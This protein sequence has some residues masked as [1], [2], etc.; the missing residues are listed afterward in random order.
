MQEELERLKRYLTYSDKLQG[1][2]PQR[3]EQL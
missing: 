3:A 1:R 2:I